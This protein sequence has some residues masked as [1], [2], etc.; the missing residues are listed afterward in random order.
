MSRLRPIPFTML[1]AAALVPLSTSAAGTAAHPLPTAPK[2]AVLLHSHSRAA[3]TAADYRITGKTPRWVAHHYRKAFA[4]QGY[5]VRSTQKGTGYAYLYM[6]SGGTYSFVGAGSGS[7][8]NG[9]VYY[10]ICVGT[11]KL[12]VDVCS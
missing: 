1:A 11:S 2:S 10:E 6:R 5:S 7:G 8:S 4:A 12:Q 9:K 3:V